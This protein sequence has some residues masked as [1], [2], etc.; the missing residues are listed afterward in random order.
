MS[1][2]FNTFRKNTGPAA[3]SI[4]YN[5]RGSVMPTNVANGSGLCIDT[6]A[7]KKTIT[8]LKTK[9]DELEIVIAKQHEMIETMWY[10]PGM[11]G[12]K[13]AEQSWDSKN[14]DTQ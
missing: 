14:G 13:E 2:S 8:D 10:A 5:S 4:G 6:I 3:L 1:S 11:P 7:D 12:Y 9:I